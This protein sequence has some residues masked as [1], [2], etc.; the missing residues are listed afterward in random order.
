MGKVA[1]TAAP[2]SGPGSLTFRKQI[3]LRITTASFSLIIP[4]SGLFTRQND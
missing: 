1:A 3:N 4:M 2:A